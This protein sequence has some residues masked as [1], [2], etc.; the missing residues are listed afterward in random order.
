M[1]K[2]LRTRTHTTIVMIYPLIISTACWAVLFAVVQV[3][4]N[5]F[6]I[7][8]KYEI[9][10]TINAVVA[11]SIGLWG[12]A[13]ILFT[14]STHDSFYNAG[15]VGITGYFL[16]DTIKLIYE[17][18]WM[19]IA[20]HL[21]SLCL[22]L[23]SLVNR[24]PYLDVATLLTELSTP[25][26]HYTL[27]INK[28]EG[29]TDAQKTYSNLAFLACFV[30]ARCILLPHAVYTCWDLIAWN[31]VTYSM[32]LGLNVY[33]TWRIVRMVAAYNALSILNTY[34]KKRIGAMVSILRAVRR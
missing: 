26:L 4:K 22:G 10:S 21:I 11:S 12:A 32:L 18:N 19:F 20:H 30:A 8:P 28:R 33:W 1:Y 29:A 15:L 7:L 25:L 9:Y 13:Q 2:P 16:I 17:R 27:W 6:G 14:G 3:V 31:R 24:T 5:Q 34:I 23:N